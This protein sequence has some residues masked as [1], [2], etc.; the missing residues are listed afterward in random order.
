M[1]NFVYYT[2]TRM[3]FGRDTQKQTGQVIAGYG[4][5]KVLL[6]YGGGS[7]KNSGLYDEV[8]ASLKESKIEVIELSGVK[9][10][11]E[12][13]LVKKGVKLC[14]ETGAELVLAVGGG[15]VIDSAKLIAIGAKSDDDPWVFS[16]KEKTPSAAL[17]V[18]VILTLAASGSEM[19]AS[20][21]ITNENGWLKRGYNSDFHRPL[22]SICNPE[23][24]YTL[25][26]FQTACGIVDIFMHTAERYF[27]AGAGTDITDRIAEGLM[28]SVLETGPFVLKNPRDYDSRA[29]LMW[30]GSLSHNDL[31]GCGRDVFM[32]V[33]QMEHEI[34][35]MYPNIAHGA[36]LSVVFPAWAKYV[37]RKDSAR[38]AQ[39]AVRVMNCDMDFESPERT[40]LEGIHR[41]ERYFSSIGMPVTMEELGV[42][43]D[44]RFDE[45]A[46]KCTFFGKRKLTAKIVLGKEEILSVFRLCRKGLN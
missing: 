18:G 40:A 13:S 42:S 6:H 34:S 39:F 21:V 17:P 5:R 12:L 16:S 32:P 4:F 29:T 38:F 44:S 30:S 37:Y 33:H 3:I 10:N 7:I 41:L 8:V 45:M 14:K 23:L 19:S 26:P 1:N 46:E 25:P 9:P 11:P 36:G 20:C 2:P 35:G 43:D 24:T 27:S 22:F 28:K 15:S 31:T